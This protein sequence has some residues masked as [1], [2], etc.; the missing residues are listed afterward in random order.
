MKNN[1]LTQKNDILAKSQIIHEIKCPVGDC[2]FR[3]PTYIGHTHNN[4][5][6]RLNQHRQSGAIM[7]HLATYLNHLTLPFHE[8]QKNVAIL[9]M[10]PETNK[11]FI[12]EALS[13]LDKKQ[14]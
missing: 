10:L 12:S 7:E 14:T 2:K 1:Y 5:R 4:R 13:I 11:L 9:K 6:T 8:L 3:N